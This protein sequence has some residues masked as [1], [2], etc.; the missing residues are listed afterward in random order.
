M[1]LINETKSGKENT[2]DN[3]ETLAQTPAA[4]RGDHLVLHAPDGEI[5]HIVIKTAS[6]T[7]GRRIDN[8]VVLDH[9]DVS[10]HHAQLT[11]DGVDY[12]ITDLNSTNGTYLDDIELK[13]NVPLIWSSEMPLYIAD[14]R[15]QLMR[16]R[17]PTGKRLTATDL[18]KLRVG[19]VA[20]EY[21]FM[22]T[23][24]Q[25][26]TAALVI[27][28]QSR[29][30]DIFNV[31]VEGLPAEWVL[32]P[33]PVRL[34]P[35][36]KQE[37]R[38]IFQPP[39]SPQSHAGRYPLVFR[40]AGQAAPDQATEV[41]GT[42]TV[43][44][45]SQFS[46]EI[47]P[48]SLES[49]QL[50][51]AVATNQGNTAETF[52]VTYQDQTGALRFEPG[53][54]RLTVPVGQTG[55]VEFKAEPRRRR[56]IGGEKIHP[57]STQISTANGEVQSHRGKVVSYGF[58]PTWLSLL[59]VMPLLALG[60]LLGLYL[61]QP[62]AEQALP[63]I[64]SVR[65]D[66]AQP[67]AGHPVTVHWRVDGAERIDLMPLVIGLEAS[68]GTYTFTQGLGGMTQ[69]TVVASNQAGRV[70][71]ALLI[72]VSEATVTPTGPVLAVWSVFPTQTSPG[73]MVTIKWQVD[74]ADSVVLEPFG[75]VDSAGEMIDQPQQS[76]T[77][78]L[79]A[80]GSQG[81]TIRRS[82]EVIV[83]TSAPNAP[84]VNRFTI[85]P[86]VLISGQVQTVRLAWETDQ[87][88]RVTIEPDIGAVGLTGFLDIPAPARDTIYTLVA[89]NKGGETRLQV[90]LRVI[91]PT[92][93]A[94]PTATITP[95]PTG[96]STATPT[97]T[98]T[99]TPTGTFTPTPT[100]TYTPT[101]TGTATSTTTPTLTPTATEPAP[102]I[103]TPES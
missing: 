70:E 48:Q 42:L 65:V 39:R 5:R 21:H 16:G 19:L 50:G 90:Q 1:T 43:T 91:T 13:P 54:S 27:H 61:F 103:A 74:Y 22:V 53:P 2:F 63:V 68:R 26:A 12:H 34:E 98:F 17:L 81:Q 46:S 7:L 59:L 69:L 15:L 23:P 58:I 11:F 67:L 95:T 55:D 101:P 51:R 80:T 29:S 77:Y 76:K 47:R 93:S 86:G 96:T 89:R 100:G 82:Q 45:F 84:K 20:Y 36:Q 99:P 32:L 102:A 87:A 72:P 3:Q 30:S 83:V 75:T 56:W 88:D 35:G 97:G 49:G 37:V 92:P 25:R 40:V 38:L 73:E 31:I 44:A 4:Q 9:P 57:F 6:L 41:D 78:T 71:Q 85:E 64:H 28:N 10:R 79:T 52:I 18:S 14:F 24:G 66:P 94:T 8:D 33:P 62:T 60:G